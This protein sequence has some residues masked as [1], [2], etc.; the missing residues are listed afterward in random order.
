MLAFVRNKDVLGDLYLPSTEKNNKIGIVWL[1][2]LPNQPKDGL[3]GSKLSEAGYTVLHPRYPGSWQSYGDFGPST[4]LDGALLGLEL[5]SKQKTFD[6]ASQ[7]EVKLDINHLILIGHSYGGGIAMCA[8]G[9]SQLSDATIVF[10]P[11]LEPHLQ[12]KDPLNPEDD[13]TTL[14]PYLKR[15]HENVFRNL[16]DIEWEKFLRGTHRCNPYNYLEVLLKKSLLLIHGEK[17]TV[18]RPYH[19]ERFYNKLK[20]NGSDSVDII[21]ING[22]GHEK[23]LPLNTFDMW[24]E[25]ITSRFN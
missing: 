3:I 22:V 11:L 1:S 17:D 20:S 6:L 23:N 18:I 2:G 4:S 19:T 5:L 16:D 12:N 9:I 14:Y 7:Q 21:K 15:C 24:T 25:W 8:Q 13:L 10:S